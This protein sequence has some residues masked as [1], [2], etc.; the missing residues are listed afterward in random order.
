MRRSIDVDA[1]VAELPVM[2]SAK[3]AAEFLRVNPRTIRR[4]AES[5]RL[6]TMKLTPEG[7]G[8]V[9]VPRSEIRR[10]LGEAAE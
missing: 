3:E 2:V 7:S 5:G 8:R 9:L 6:R 10:L 4:W 1:L